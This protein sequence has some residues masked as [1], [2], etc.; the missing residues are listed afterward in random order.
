MSRST[1]AYHHGNLPEALERAAMGLLETQPAA[2]ISLRA[3]AREAG[4]SHNAPYHH[5]G[6]RKALLKVL[7][8]RSMSALLE[9]QRTSTRDGAPAMRLRALAHD[10]VTFASARPHVFAVIYDPSVCVPGSPTETMAPLI[11][12]EEALLADT[13]R[14][15]LPEIEGQAAASMAAAMWG[16]VHGLAQ[17]SQAGHL[18]LE[19]ALSAVDALLDRVVASDG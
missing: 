2:E 15:A 7:A 11:A 12:A 5:F 10:Y 14:A 13:V 8:E 9:S 3:V 4:V 16:T 6:D 18:P 17:L 19:G 1:S